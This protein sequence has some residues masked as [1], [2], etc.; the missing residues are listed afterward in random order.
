MKPTGF[1][2]VT[3]MLVGVNESITIKLK[4]LSDPYHVGRASWC[5]RPP[6]LISPS[7]LSPQGT[8]YMDNTLQEW[9]G[10]VEIDGGNAL[11][12]P[13]SVVFDG[14]NQGVFNGDKRPIKH[15][16]GWKWSKPGIYW[17]NVIDRKTG[18]RGVSNP[19]IVKEKVPGKRIFWGDIH[20]Q[21]YFSDGLRFPE[22]LYYFAR[23]EAF[24]DFG[25][26]TDHSEALTDRQWEYFVGVANDFNAPGDFATLVGFEWSSGYG[27]RNIYYK[28]EYGPILRSDDTNFCTLEKL[29]CA[30]NKRKAVVIPHHS[31]NITIGVDWSYGWN[32]EYEKAVEIYSIW[33]N[34]ECSQSNGNP[35]PIKFDGGEKQGRHVIDPLR[36]GYRFG[37][38]GSGD[39]HDGRPGDELHALQ[40]SVYGYEMLYP[41]G[42]TAAILEGLTR[43]NLFEAICSHNTYATTKKRIYM[44]FFVDDTPMGG[45]V[46]RKSS[47]E[48]EV[49]LICA[50]DEEIENAVLIG[51]EDVICSFLPSENPLIVHA[52]K[53]IKI[54]TNFCYLRVI[55]KNGNMAWASPIWFD[56]K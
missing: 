31:A 39:I 20:W 54:N 12:G 9:E 23:D 2:V 49:R 19:V 10:V 47:E 24:L 27:H 38:I 3:P 6:R 45:S 55:T 34:S 37:F 18:V 53:R 28:D 43:E 36:L 50:A 5:L 32:P 40:K 11:E 1:L 25:A 42:F 4:V 21:S 51:C 44:E 13:K 46:Q 15:C 16:G 48:Y 56:R 14:K 52:I 29:W 35:R 8:D 17:I 33:G 22:E 41:Q 30:L 7:N 26:A